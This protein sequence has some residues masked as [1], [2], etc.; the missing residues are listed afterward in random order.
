MTKFVR[1]IST[2]TLPAHWASFLVNGDASGLEPGEA[3]RIT[4]HLDNVLEP[5][6]RVIDVSRDGEGEALE[7]RFTW[8]FRLHGSDAEGGNVLDFITRRE[9]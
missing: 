2:V 5:D 1:D 8:S 7:P 3:S 9:D 4:Q 6:W